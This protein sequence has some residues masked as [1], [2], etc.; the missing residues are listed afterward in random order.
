MR[1]LPE[2]AVAGFTDALIA[3]RFPFLDADQ[4]ASTS[5]FVLS[6]WRVASQPVRLGT[7]AVATVLGAAAWSLAAMA[8][9]TQGSG[10]DA[11]WG[12]VV[13]G[14]SRRPLPGISELSQFVVSLATAYAADRW[15]DAALA[16][17]A[18]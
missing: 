11:A 4:Q 5:T 13:H 6:R 15:P 17:Q 16:S 18:S 10:R 12:K 3:E 8:G 14:L 2:R 9:S 7:G 1:A